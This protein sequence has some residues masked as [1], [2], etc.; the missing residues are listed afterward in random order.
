MSIKIT[1]SAK[2]D[3][4]QFVR[5][6]QLPGMRNAEIGP[7]VRNILSGE[8]LYVRNP[9]RRACRIEGTRPSLVT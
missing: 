5:A 1:L 6:L 3:G 8:R 2:I 4:D 9:G 7:E